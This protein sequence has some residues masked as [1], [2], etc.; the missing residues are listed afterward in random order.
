MT[1]HSPADEVTTARQ[2]VRRAV[3]DLAAALYREAYR[4]CHGTPAQC[5]RAAHAAMD[6][7]LSATLRDE[8]AAGRRATFDQPVE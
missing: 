6:H 8:L 1:D 5:Q 2:Q 7:A 3:A 4:A